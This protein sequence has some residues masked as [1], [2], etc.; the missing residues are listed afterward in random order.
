MSHHP[1]D[2]EHRMELARQALSAS[3]SLMESNEITPA[4]VIPAIDRLAIMPTQPSLYAEFEDG[5]TQD[6]GLRMPEN[7]GVLIFGSST[8]PGG[9]WLNGA[10]AQE[11]DVSLASTWGY[12]A[13]E[14]GEDFYIKDD[15]PS[16]IGPDKVLSAKGYWLFD[17]YG[18]PLEKKIPAH[19]ISV[20]APNLATSEAQRL[21]KDILIETLGRRIATALEVWRQEGVENVLMGAIGCGVFKW[22]ATDS[23]IA[24]SKGIAHFRRRYGNNMKI[25]FA[26]VD[27]DIKEA[28]D[29]VLGDPR[30]WNPAAAAAKT[31]KKKITRRF[32]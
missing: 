29:R 22:D 7:T 24:V 11:E 14:G 18:Y 15:S 16:G 3:K 8:Q 4:T 32:Y 31:A 13:T 9:G 2:K 5:F 6:V 27:P 21:R 19:F 28:Y 17:Q 23:A 20:S 25:T 1:K 30:L 10:K 12:Q 26:M